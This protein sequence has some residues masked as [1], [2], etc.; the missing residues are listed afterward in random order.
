MYDLGKHR[1]GQLVVPQRSGWYPPLLALGLLLFWNR[2]EYS[3]S[4]ASTE[5]CSEHA[6]RHLIHCSEEMNYAS[7]LGTDIVIKYES[8]LMQLTMPNNST[9]ED[10]LLYNGFMHN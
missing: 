3:P 10:S 7:F 6:D 1:Q 8:Y 5:P 2:L 4:P 9:G